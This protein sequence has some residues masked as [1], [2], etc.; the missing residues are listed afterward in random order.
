MPHSKEDYEF[1]W[2]PEYKNGWMGQ[3][4]RSNFTAP[5]SNAIEGAPTE[6]YT[7]PTAEHWMMCCKAALFGDIETM[8]MLLQETNPKRVKALG[9]LVRPFDEEKWVAAREKIVF[10]GN[11]AKFSQDHEL[12][13]MLLTTGDKLLVEASSFDRIWGIGFN[14]AKAMANRERWGLNI[15]GKALMEVRSRLR[16]EEDT[17]L[18]MEE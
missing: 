3:W 4:H 13:A 5:L 15:L 9:R 8:E 10:E 16:E 2:K 7:F 6:L 17:D 12:K 18:P 1:F 14:E 11:L